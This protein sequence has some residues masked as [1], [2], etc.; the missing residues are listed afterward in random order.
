[1]EL[2]YSVGDKVYL[3]GKV[4]EAHSVESGIFYKIKVA[5]NTNSITVNVDEEQIVEKVETQPVETPEEEL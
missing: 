2:K 5:T 1:M 4:L 3:E